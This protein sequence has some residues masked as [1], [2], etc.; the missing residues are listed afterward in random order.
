MK[1]LILF[2]LSTAGLVWTLNKSK[3]FKGLRE[4]ISE[5]Y[6]KNQD[7]LFWWFSHSL[8]DCSGCM[9][10]WMSGATYYLIFINPVP[11]I[12]YSFIGAI[13]SVVIITFYQKLEK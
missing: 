9:G 6:L 7:N 3:L 5:R 10:V 13:C 1:E 11:F 12:Y 2:I 4:W 8:F